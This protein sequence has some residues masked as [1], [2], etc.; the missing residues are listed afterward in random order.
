MRGTTIASQLLEHM[1]LVI[2]PKI[3]PSPSDLSHFSICQEHSD[4]EH[5]LRDQVDTGLNTDTTT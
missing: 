5:R 2:Q 3:K 4:R 1:S